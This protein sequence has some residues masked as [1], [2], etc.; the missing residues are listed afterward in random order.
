MSPSAS[1]PPYPRIAFGTCS[2][3]EPRCTGCAKPCATE[4][5]S[6]SKNAHEK[7]ERVLMLVEYALRFSAS[8]ISSVAA[9]SAFR[10]TSNVIG[11]TRT[12]LTTPPPVSDT[13]QRQ[14]PPE[15]DSSP[16]LEPRAPPPVSDTCQR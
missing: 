2:L 5:S 7:S 1:S 11:S 6:A 14:N 8:T 4:R 12:T 3:I 10:T 15:Q 13:P 9:T 16:S